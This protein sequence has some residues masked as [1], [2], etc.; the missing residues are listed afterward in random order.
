MPQTASE[1]AG[2]AAAEA[3]QHYELGLALC[4]RGDRRAALASFE[5]A[6]ALQHDHV[7]ALFHAGEM[8]A[9]LGEVEEAC[10]C[11][12]LALAFDPRSS[13]SRIALA[14]LLLEHQGMEAAVELLSD[15]LQ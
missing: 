9:E 2:T 11:F 13:A 4:G 14:G 8:H 6:I 10:D 5:R 7:P 12:N 3:R 15:A 1:S